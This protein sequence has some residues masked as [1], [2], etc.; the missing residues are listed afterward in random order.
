VSTPFEVLAA[1]V[2][3]IGR[4]VRAFT[5]VVTRTEQT[6]EAAHQAL[7]GLVD[8]ILVVER[9]VAEAAEQVTAASASADEEQ[10]AVQSWLAR[11]Q[12][13]QLV[14]L[15]GWT[16]QV[17]I[18]YPGTAEALRSCW[19]YHPWAVE[20][21]LALHAAWRE[22]YVGKRV[23]G[24]RAVDWHDRHRPG[25]LARLRKELGDCSIEAHEPGR[26][27]DHRRLP[28]VA[29]GEYVESAVGWWSSSLGGASSL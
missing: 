21:L 17:L 15:A 27:A 11:P 7:D 12:R 1:R 13:A 24:G 26:R 2:D 8:R 16:E 6:A 28:T 29:G 25:V 19:P 5:E 20:E 22:A 10:P 18:H 4:H 9:L 23:N 3:A 14:E